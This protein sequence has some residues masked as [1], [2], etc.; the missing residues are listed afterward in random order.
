MTRFDYDAY[1]G[2]R[3][4]GGL[5]MR[6]LNTADRQFSA[7]YNFANAIHTDPYTSIIVISIYF[8][9]NPSMPAPFFMDVTEHTKPAKP[10]DIP[11]LQEFFSIPGKSSDTTG[12]RNM[13]SLTRELDAPKDSRVSFSTI[14]FKNDLRVLKYAHEMYKKVL[15]NL[16]AQAKGN[17]ALYTLYQ[18]IPPLF[19][20]H[21][22]ERGGNV[23]GLDRFKDNLILYEPYLRWQG[24]D[25]DDLFNGQARFLREEISSY[26]KSI[27]ADN[28]W[29]Y[30]NY[31]DVDQHPLESYGAENVERIRAAAKKYDPQGVF[32]DMM[33]GGFKI[34]K[35]RT[36]PSKPYVLEGERSVLTGVFCRSMRSVWQRNIKLPEIFAGPMRLLEGC[37]GDIG[38]SLGIWVDHMRRREV[39]DD[40]FRL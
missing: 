39:F 6:S 16:Q 3:I 35:V 33:P 9:N 30:L 29:I 2:G 11:I 22:N 24:S 5:V 21:S 26:A 23:L 12:L 28:P 38:R 10:S 27:G 37:L 8:A 18:P 32:Q 13:T 4:F 7:L 15:A 40:G 17:W 34:S 36:E 1:E 25:Q 19:S 20:Q 31:A 14:T